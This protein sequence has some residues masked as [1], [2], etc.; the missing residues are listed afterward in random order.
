MLIEV[1]ARYELLFLSVQCDSFMACFGDAV[2]YRSLSWEADGTQPFDQHA[3]TKRF[4]DE[5]W[6]RIWWLVD[7]EGRGEAGCNLLLRRLRRGYNV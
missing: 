6:E 4:S 1:Q 5:A 3:S 7:T 2:L